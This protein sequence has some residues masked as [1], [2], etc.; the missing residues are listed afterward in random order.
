MV[1]SEPRFLADGNTLPTKSRDIWA[2]A[3]SGLVVGGLVESALGVFSDSL[4]SLVIGAF[5]GGI[6]GAYVLYGKVGQAAAA[7]A[8]AGGLGTPFFLGVSQI[9]FIFEVIHPPSGPT[10]PVSELQV[11][12]ILLLALNVLAGAVGGTLAGA[13]RHP[14][15]EAGPTQP[16]GAPLGAPQQV[17]YC[18]QCGAQLPTGVVVCPHCNARQPG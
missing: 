6:V 1:Y 3:L 9:L 7:G 15:Q 10:P 8:L 18:V 13:V 16:S 14:V 5:V 17:R 12:V 11:P 2:A 4:F